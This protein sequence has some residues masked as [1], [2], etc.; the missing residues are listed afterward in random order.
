MSAIQ[1]LN[2]V[3]TSIPWATIGQV[4]GASGV[5][6]FVLV[7]V[8]KKVDKWFVHHKQMMITLVGLGGVL[9]A[10]T[11]YL[12]QTPTQNPGIIAMQG[13]MIAFVSQPFYLI[14]VKP[15]VSYIATTVAKAAAFNEQVESAKSALEPMDAPAVPITHTPELSEVHAFDN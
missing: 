10:A 6:S 4:I 15:L 12:M 5:L 13:L 9:I 1:T 14:I 2:Q 7:P 11:H 3:A 8:K